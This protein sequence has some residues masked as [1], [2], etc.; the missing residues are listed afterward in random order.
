M[1]RALKILLAVLS[2]AALFTLVA[3]GN[4]SNTGGTGYDKNGIPVELKKSYTGSASGYG[5]DGNMYR[6]GGDTLTFNIT[7][8]TITNSDKEKRYFKVLTEKNLGNSKS[9]PEALSTFKRH[10]SELKGKKYFLFTSV[11]EARKDKLDANA[12]DPSEIYC[13]VLSDGGKSIRIFQLETGNQD[14]YYNFT[15]EAN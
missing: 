8:Q 14:E 10:K 1:K 2:V 9:F 5:Y 7:Q 12:K 4:K 11:T 3:C 15:G 13:V 6:S